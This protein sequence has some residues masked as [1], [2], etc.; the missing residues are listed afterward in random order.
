M[1]DEIIESFPDGEFLIADGLDEAILGIDPY[2]M[3]LIY[4]IER[5]HDIFMKRDG[6]TS[7]DAMEFFDFNVAGAHMGEHTPIWL[8]DLSV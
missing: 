5:I 8:D 6:M 7:D 3:V 4:S 1:L 2:K